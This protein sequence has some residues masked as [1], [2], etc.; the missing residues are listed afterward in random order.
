M[1]QITNRN[2][3][4]KAVRDATLDGLRR[5]YLI[6]IGLAIAQA[7]TR[8]FTDHDI[9]LAAKLLTT[10]HLVQLTLLV[11]FLPTAIRFAHGTM[12]HFS[13]LTGARKWRVDMLVLLLQA[14]L[15][16]VAALAL[17]DTPLFIFFYAI[18]YILDTAWLFIVSEFGHPFERMERQWVVSNSCQLILIGLLI[19]LVSR[20]GFPVI[21]VGVLLAMGSLGATYWDYFHNSEHYFPTVG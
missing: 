8:A 11:A 10:P 18:I 14:L 19:L 1:N 7:L 9:F 4:P 16:F 3:E 12:L 20:V 2:P 15:F 5:I 17:D 13:V 21:G 6:I